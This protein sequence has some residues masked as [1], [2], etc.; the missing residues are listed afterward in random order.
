MPFSRRFPSAIFLAGLVLL[1]FPLAFGQ[2][3][4]PPDFS[5]DTNLPE[6]AVPLGE[7]DSLEVIFSTTGGFGEMLGEK[8]GE[9]DQLER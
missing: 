9:P 7:T 4:P 2:T 1:A 6:L 5:L 8:L 3:P